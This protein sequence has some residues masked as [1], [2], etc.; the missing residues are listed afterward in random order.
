[1]RQH[2]TP[3]HCK[4]YCTTCVKFGGKILQPRCQWELWCSDARRPCTWG[5][6]WHSPPYPSL[7]LQLLPNT[8]H[9]ESFVFTLS[10]LF[11][12]EAFPPL[13]WPSGGS[14]KAAFNQRVSQLI[15]RGTT[16][17]PWLLLRVEAVCVGEP[18]GCPSLP[19]SCHGPTLAQAAAALWPRCATSEKRCWRAAKH[20]AKGGEEPGKEVVKETEPDKGMGKMNKRKKTRNTAEEAN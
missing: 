11:L 17:I 14:S 1:M 13:P 15:F 8:D 19:A 2:V 12:H 7:S 5:L 18:R 20:G 6:P 3:W 9:A 4:I 16:T 10:F